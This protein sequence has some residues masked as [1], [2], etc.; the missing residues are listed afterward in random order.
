MLGDGEVA[1]LDAG[2]EGRPLAR[3]ESEDGA[4]WILGVADGDSIADH[5]YLNTLPR[6]AIP[7]ALPGKRWL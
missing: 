5:G 2:E 4:V 3:R 6:I 7:A 1:I